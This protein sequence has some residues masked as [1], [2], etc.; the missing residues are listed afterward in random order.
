MISGSNTPLT[1]IP[2]KQPLETPIVSSRIRKSVNPVCRCHAW[3]N[4]INLWSHSNPNGHSDR[5][6]E[7]ARSCRVW[8]DSLQT[9]DL[10]STPTPALPKTLLWHAGKRRLFRIL[11]P[12]RRLDRF[13]S[14]ARDSFRK[15][16]RDGY[17]WVRFDRV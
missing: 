6:T 15:S 7:P 17:D 16:E 4:R 8:S 13:E 10:V 11:S 5:G 2:G 14:N 1:E 9:R 12:H 3:P